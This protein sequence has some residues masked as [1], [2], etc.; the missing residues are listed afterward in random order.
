MLNQLPNP[1]LLRLRTAIT[2]FEADYLFEEYLLGIKPEELFNEFLDPSIFAF[3]IE[4]IK[5]KGFEEKDVV[6]LLEI[7]FNYFRRFN[8]SENLYE[9]QLIEALKVA[10]ENKRMLIAALL[11]EKLI[12]IFAKKEIPPSLDPEKKSD[13]QNQS[14]SPEIAKIAAEGQLALLSGLIQKNIVKNINAVDVL[15]RN[16]L[17]H[18]FMGRQAETFRYLL[19]QKADLNCAEQVFKKIQG[20]I[21]NS[22][23]SFSQKPNY[24]DL[25]YQY[26]LKKKWLE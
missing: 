25:K 3:L 21:P 2:S 23:P 9:N 7:V 12:S 4:K 10:K 20:A 15:G 16:L 6:K 26:T 19:K 24:I 17:M 13:S 18:A 22:N 1:H 8:V 5:A 14:L 11:K